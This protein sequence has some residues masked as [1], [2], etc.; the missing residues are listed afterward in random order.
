VRSLADIEQLRSIG[1]DG[2]LV[3]SALLDGNITER[4]LE[5]Y[6]APST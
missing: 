5:C 3:A 1:C 6:L 4:D 2:A